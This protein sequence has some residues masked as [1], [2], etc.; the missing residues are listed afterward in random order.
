MTPPNYLA[1]QVVPKEVV[2]DLLAICR[3]LYATRKN[4]GAGLDELAL[5]EQAGKAFAESLSMVHC[6]GNTIGARAAWSW[7][8]KG[9]RLLGEALSG[10]QVAVA[11]L[12][13]NWGT[14]LKR[15]PDS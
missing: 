14:K 6:E 4:D 2:R 7:A 1:N 3:V 13:A 8:E 5:I 15:F 9:L 11:Q 12:V 10:Q